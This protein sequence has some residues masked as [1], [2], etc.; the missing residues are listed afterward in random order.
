[1]IIYGVRSGSSKG[2][3]LQGPRHIARSVHSVLMC[4]TVR[5]GAKYFFI[6]DQTEL[7]PFVVPL[8]IR[9]FDRSLTTLAA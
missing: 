4:G 6:I 8:A 5:V 2:A 1:M 7:P 3:V 9:G